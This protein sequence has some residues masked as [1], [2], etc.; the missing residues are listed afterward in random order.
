MRMLPD[1]CVPWPV[2]RY[3]VGRH[4]A[5]VRERVRDGIKNGDLLCTLGLNV[6]RSRVRGFAIDLWLDLPK[7]FSMRSVDVLRSSVP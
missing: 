3:L 5:A 2:E 6:R 7:N 4:C 1:E